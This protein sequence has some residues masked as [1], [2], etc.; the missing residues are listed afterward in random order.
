MSETITGGCHCGNLTYR[1]Q[2]G[3]LLA[4]HCQC[5]NCRKISA[6]GHAS[7]MMLPMS[8]VTV[9]GEETTYEVTADSGNTVT[10]HFCPTCGTQVY[11]TN[12]GFPD[13]IFVTA[14]SLDDPSIFS[15]QMLVYAKRGPAWDI[16]DPEIPHFEGMPPPETAQV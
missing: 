15:P 3:Q 10:R 2:S 14:A 6:T 1:S 4:G 12:S 5:L 13:A 7:F 9:S 11:S 16:I 8:A